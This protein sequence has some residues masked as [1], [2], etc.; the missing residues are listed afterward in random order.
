LSKPKFIKICRAEEEEEEDDDDD[1][2]GDPSTVDKLSVPTSNCHLLSSP[3]FY[4]FGQHY[5]SV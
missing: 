5:S 1:C 2:T 4:N 3:D